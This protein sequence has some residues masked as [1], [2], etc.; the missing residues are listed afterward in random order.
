MRDVVLN[1]ATKLIEN[2]YNFDEIRMA[3]LKYGLYSMYTFL[4]KILVLA[5]IALV[6]GIFKEFIIFVFFYN[7]LR[8]Y[9]CGFHANTNFQ[10]WIFSFI[11]FIIIPLFS[12]MFVLNMLFKLFISLICS[13]ILI[14]YAPADTHNKPIIN[15]FIRRRKK[16]M[17]FISCLIYLIIIIFSKNML[18]TNLI[19]L[20][21]IIE[22]IFINPI[23]YKIFNQTYNNY[24]Y[25]KH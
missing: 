19:M 23:I 12:K 20:S 9:G 13:L 5:I 17:M 2:K 6:L 22:S 8:I 18:L 4:T 15:R 3:E 14:K 11:S 10:C 25:Y 21:L 16:T 24:K 7:F 1:S